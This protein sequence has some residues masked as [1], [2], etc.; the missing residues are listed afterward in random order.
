MKAITRPAATILLL[1]LVSPYSPAGEP[2][3]YWLEQQGLEP[4]EWGIDHDGDTRTARDEYAAGTDPFDPASR[5]GLSI[6]S[7][8]PDI[9]LSWDSPLGVLY[10][11]Q[12]TTDMS[13]FA[14]LMDP[15]PGAGAPIDVPVPLDQPSSFYR[16]SPLFPVDDDGD[17]LS[18]VEEAML[19]TN[20]NNSDTDGD[21]L[22]D[23]DE[24]CRHLTD[25]LVFDPTSGS[26]QGTVFTDPDHDGDLADGEPLAQ[27]TVFLDANFNGRFD[28]GERREITDGDGNYEFIFV[29]PG[30]HHVL[31][32]LPAPSVQTFPVDGQAPVFNMLP[33]EVVQYTHAAPGVG[34]VDE[35]YGQLA[36][37]WP[38][39]WDA[40]DI[41]PGVQAVSPDIVLKPIGVRGRAGGGQFRYGTEYISLPTGASI[42]LRFDE[43]IVDGPGDDLIL[44][45]LIG[46][47][48]NEVAE[49]LIGS[50]ADNL[51]SIGEAAES[52][53]V[54]GIDL[55]EF[56]LPGPIYFVQVVGK[57]VGGSTK[58]FDFVG[59]EAINVA[60][61]YPGAHIVTITSNEVVSGRDFG[62]YFRDLPPT[63]VIGSEDGNPATIGLL[64]GEP[65]IVQVQAFD[66]IGIEAVSLTV[67]GQAVVLDPGRQATL[68][69]SNPGEIFLEATATDTGGQTSSTSA[70]YYIRNSDGTLPF[71]PS[72]IGQSESSAPAAPRARILSPGP[73]TSSGEDIAII[74]TITASPAPTSWT[75]E[76][77]PVDDI[78][79]YNLSADDPDYVELA[80]GS[81][82][83]FSSALGTLPLDSLPDGIYFVRV[84][85]RNSPTRVSCFGQVVA[86]NVAESDLRPEV[87][88][89][90]PSPGSQVMVTADITGTITSARPL[91]EWFVECA[92]AGQVDLNNLGAPGPDWKRIA[93]GTAEIPTSSVIAQL[94]ATLLK[95]DGY[96]VRIVARND[97]GLGWVEPLAL[98]VTGEIKLGRNRL[99][100]RDIS[101][102]LAGFP[103]QFVR[104]YDSFQSGED[105][106]LGYG[107]SLDLQDADI[108][109]TV[110]DTGSLG[111]FGSTPFRDG[112]RVYITAPT[113]ERLGFTF[114]PEVGTS[115][116][117]GAVY[118]AAFVPD[119]GVYHTLEI[120]EGGLPFLD[121]RAD[122]N[123]Y[124]YFFGFPYNPEK[125]VLTEPGGKRYTYH[126][127]KGFLRAEDPNGNSITL[128]D[129]SLRHSSGLGIDFARD[130]EGRIQ[131]ILSPD[132]D[133]WTFGYSPAGDLES[134]TDPGG[135][136]T[137]YSYFSE[138]A[139]YLDTITDPL[140][141]IPVRYEYDPAD[142]R[143]VAMID[144]E[145][146]RSEVAWNP[147]GFSGSRK[148]PRGFTS[149]VTY[150][151]RGN[152]LEEVD[153]GG[154]TTT[155][156]YT[157]A[158]NPD[159]PTSITGADG[160]TWEMQYDTM[161]NPTRITPPVTGVG[162]ANGVA[163]FSYD[164]FGNVTESRDFKNRTSNFAY[165]ERG[166]L[167][168]QRPAYGKALDFELS[169]AGQIVRMREDGFYTIDIGYD[170]NGH[171][172]SVGDLL[173]YQTGI[174]TKRS[175][176]IKG[177]TDNHGGTTSVQFD[178]RGIPGVQMD[179]SGASMTTVESPDGSL[180]ST[181]RNGI[182]NHLAVDAHGRIDEMTIGG[183]GVVDPEYD[184][185]GNLATV[186]DP[187]DNTFT[188][189]Y[190]ALERRTSVS[191]ETGATLTYT[192]N[193]LGLLE[194][195]TT[196]SGKKRSYAYDKNRHLVAERWHAPDD[197]I[198]REYV[199]SYRTSGSLNT[200][201]DTA[202][203]LTHLH[204]VTGDFPQPGSIA[205]TY[206]GQTDFT[207]RYAWGG[208]AGR[209][210][211]PTS[212]R[213]TKNFGN[214][215]EIAAEYIGK[216]AYA[217]SWSGTLTGGGNNIQIRRNP[218]GSIASQTRTT[219][220]G[221]GGH[222]TSLFSYNASGMLQRIRHEDPDGNLIHPEAELAY[223]YDAGERIA[224]IAQTSNTATM[225][226]DS[227][228]RL[229]TVGNSSASIPDESYSYDL[230]G[231]R[232]GSHQFA[233]T[234][235]IG[236]ANRL[237]AAGDFTYSYDIDGNV[238]E[239]SNTSTGE[240]ARF[241]YNH[242]NLLVLATVHP[243]AAEPAATTLRFDYD[244]DNRLISREIDGV[245]TW[246]LYD[247]KMP[248]AEFADGADDVN[249][250]FFYSPDQTDDLHAVWREGVGERWFLKDHLGSIRGTLDETGNLISWVDYDP[251]GNLQGTAPAG[252]EPTRFAGRYFYDAL[253]LYE[254]R[255]RFYDPWLGR[256]IQTDPIHINGRDFNLYAY[257]G[258][259]P[260]SFT[261]PL[262][263]SAIEWGELVD[264][265]S[266]YVTALC[267]LGNCVGTLWVGVVEGVVNLTPPANPVP[268]QECTIE[269]IGVDP[270]S[271]NSLFGFGGG[272]LSALVG[273]AG[274]GPG[275]RDL[276]QGFGFLFTIK[277]TVDSC[278]GMSFEAKT[279]KPCEDGFGL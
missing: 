225:G 273:T 145:G 193:E 138:P 4:W 276:G 277:G 68:T 139:H 46:G 15:I 245:K 37:D 166:N 62:R 237:T 259:N 89:D 81:G 239:R 223:T 116:A 115:S 213:V 94:D 264:L 29:P 22:L 263:T 52:G 271:A 159:K 187:L 229:A 59:I 222:S 227:G 114:K 136:T 142:G 153:P 47:P 51:L 87:H 266:F 258:N 53:S 104:V 267:R 113:G 74:G 221:G 243:S 157:D 224:S 169:P 82:N 215:V 72:R 179:P 155:Y 67:D 27:V 38:A 163:R 178:N 231:N 33:D 208:D 219:S 20:P 2:G 64:A 92:P 128:N 34:N 127:D 28:D 77:A 6:F 40:I 251:F 194:T 41:G 85:A 170:A 120:P 168:Q 164:A 57:D 199:L 54:T 90:S 133:S 91:R 152:V 246:I 236:A 122:G 24:V 75:L 143:L 204:Q 35:P 220:L 73:G 93:E 83:V 167:V 214:R 260:L 44:Y 183:G 88:I 201:E 230:I 17:G 63:V 265:S 12:E 275:S 161:G 125:Y 134:V 212:V 173:G 181:D 124:L 154:N 190:D 191:D 61:P 195:V 247:R 56:G 117:F 150:D 49:I 196:A 66:D 233:G 176:Q 5:L 185:S 7:V 65:L 48:A 96:I 112:T 107:W 254:N 232:L 131:S 106:E 98:D 226:Y 171:P 84:C 146:N 123:V 129:G 203:G 198:I 240:M 55:G 60:P 175:G 262:G 97:I 111:L 210:D 11:L 140:G 200:I 102:N 109:E 23:G 103:L 43:P 86:K 268:I 95:S 100:F 165:D 197:S 186:T 45:P 234:A 209:E 110:P 207:I 182:V 99:E 269:F 256:F 255:F 279:K 105:G 19:G 70:T 30:L 25:P 235:T 119:S 101:I 42:T 32:L 192:Y 205:V 261:D 184:A 228:D 252:L 137:T 217:L 10:Q 218:D 36:S 18:A 149:N 121:L 189:G 39:Q 272:Y 31:Q 174:E 130:A 132:G 274:P 126:E 211:N 156:T 26:I 162:V 69:L 158:A 160:E 58:G 238:A 244:Y 8:P 202:G 80:R 79:P 148:S 177:I 249:A 9:V 76:Y 188:F 180:T 270:C 250:V 14:P 21:G 216:R 172:S 71:D 50:D 108:R 206:A 242:R 144:G 147:G 13:R 78:D 278:K 257:A 1:L 151:E 248:I 135:R 141:R 253:G 241:E 16:L 3:S 118:R